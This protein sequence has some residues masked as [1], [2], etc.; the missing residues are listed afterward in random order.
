MIELIAYINVFIHICVIFS[1][2]T[3]YTKYKEL[4]SLFHNEKKGIHK[5]ISNI[6]TKIKTDFETSNNKIKELKINLDALITSSNKTNKDIASNLTNLSKK[7]SEN[8][9]TFEV[10]KSS[11]FDL[12]IN[13]DYLKENNIVEL[14]D[15]LK[16]NKLPEIVTLSISSLKNEIVNDMTSNI[17]STFLSLKDEINTKF[18]TYTV[19]DNKIIDEINQLSEVSKSINNKILSYNDFINSSISENNKKFNKKISDV[20]YK[21]N[22]LQRDIDTYLDKTYMIVGFHS[23]TVIPNVILRTNEYGTAPIRKEVADYWNLQPSYQVVN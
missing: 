13:I 15:L 14:I 5:I 3:L 1:I 16:K 9:T 12:N 22:I 11:N 20:R 17:S 23:G 6:N 19:T 8:K 2:Y 21:Y 4:L 10:M 7:C 18:T